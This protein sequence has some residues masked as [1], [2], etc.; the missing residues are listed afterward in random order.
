MFARSAAARQGPHSPAAALAGRLLDE[1]E[2]FAAVRNEHEV[3]L[4]HTSEKRVVHPEIG[5]LQ[6][7]SV[8]GSQQLTSGPGATQGRAAH[9]VTGG[10]GGARPRPGRSDPDVA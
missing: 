2:E 3:G 5:T 1:S 7:L 4:V 8:I 10:P 6:L 9:R